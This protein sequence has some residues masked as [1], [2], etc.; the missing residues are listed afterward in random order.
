MADR[1]EVNKGSQLAQSSVADEKGKKKD[2]EKESGT[3]WLARK[4]SGRPISNEQMSPK[5]DDAGKPASPKRAFFF[6]EF[7]RKPSFEKSKSAENLDD[8]VTPV[9]QKATDMETETLDNIR[10]EF[11]KKNSKTNAASQ[12]RP[13][14]DNAADAAAP[15]TSEQLVTATATSQGSPAAPSSSSDLSTKPASSAQRDGNDAEPSQSRINHVSRSEATIRVGATRTPRNDAAL[16]IKVTRAAEGKAASLIEQLKVDISKTQHSIAEINSE[17]QTIQEALDPKKSVLQ[18][19]VPFFVRIVTKSTVAFD[20]RERRALALT[21]TCLCDGVCT[22]VGCVRQ[23]SKKRCS[24]KESSRR[25]R[26]E[27]AR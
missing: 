18:V 20:R 12:D 14:S 7:F 16:G 1:N 19:P 9:S 24:G 10:S 3:S 8:A 27:E 15:T 6:G 22:Y 11:K 23:K 26:E 2:K 21:Y 4:L 13:A 5:S 25:S 17:I